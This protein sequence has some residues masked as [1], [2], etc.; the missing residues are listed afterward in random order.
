MVIEFWIFF[1]FFQKIVVDS[2]YLKND[3]CS[4]ETHKKYIKSYIVSFKKKI[5]KNFANSFY[6]QKKFLDLQQQINH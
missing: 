1:A 5:K 6:F 2:Q 4:I 3:I